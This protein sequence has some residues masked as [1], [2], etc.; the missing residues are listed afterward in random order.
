MFGTLN[1]REAQA[2]LDQL[3]QKLIW[4]PIVLVLFRAWSTLRWL[5]ASTYPECSNIDHKCSLIFGQVWFTKECLQ[6]I[7]HP[8]LVY[9]QSI[10]DT[11][12]GWGNALLYVIFN[13]TI[14]KRLCPCLYCCWIRVKNCCPSRRR[15]SEYSPI[16]YDQDKRQVQLSDSASYVGKLTNTKT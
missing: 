9:M 11:G 6:V 2:A 1:K 15:R 7:Y 4:I 16:E 8:F 10:G 12:Q 14:F 13:A 5:I 3:D